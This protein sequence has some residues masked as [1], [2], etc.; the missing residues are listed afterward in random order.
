MNASRIRGFLIQL[1]KPAKIR[2][3]AG[4][5]EPQEIKP[6]RSYARTADSIEALGVDLIECLDKDGSVLRALRL[7][8]PESRRSDAADVPRGIEADPHALMLSHFANLLHRAYEHST[9][10]AFTRLVELAERLSAHTESI[11][12]R[13][14]HT[15]SA[16]RREQSDRIDEAYERAREAFEKGDATSSDPLMQQ[17]MAAFMGARVPTSA[18]NGAAKNGKG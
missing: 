6:S 5:G 9:E 8:E 16:L 4:D 13:L 10:I 3:S 15:E 2:V 14:A 17:M 11:E 18:P 7:S 1:P 12:A